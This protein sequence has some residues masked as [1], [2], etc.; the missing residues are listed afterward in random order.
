MPCPENLVGY[1]FIIKGKVGR[2]RRRSLSFLSRHHACIISS[3]S[4]LSRGIFL[5]LHGQAKPT[6]YYF[7]CVQRACPRNHELTELTGQDVGLMPPLFYC[8]GA[9]L[10]LL[11]HGFVAKQACSVLWLSKPF[12]SNH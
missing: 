5:F 4:R 12:L 3:S 10:M 2:R 7:L 9:H 6:N 1:S 11:L 8:L